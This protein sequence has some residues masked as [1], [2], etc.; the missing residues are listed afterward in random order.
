[1]SASR[2]KKKRFEERADGTDK[3]QVREQNTA[4]NQKRKKLITRIVAIVVVL[5]LLVCIVINSNLFYTG[6]TAV[7]AGDWK[8]TTADFNYEYFNVYYNTYTN[9]Y[10]YYGDYAYLLL[11]PSKSLEDQNYSEEQTWDEY[12]EE[13]AFNQLQQMAILND[14]GKAEGWELD[15]DQLAEIEANIDSIKTEAISQG[16]SDYR[17]YLRALYKKG[18]TEDRL[19]TLLRQS[20]YATYY[21]ADLSARW[22]DS[23]T[24]EAKADYYAGVANTYDLFTYMLYFVDGSVGED[25]ELDADTALNQARDIAQEIASS[26]DQATFADAVYE[27]APEDSKSTYADPNA[28]LQRYVSVSSI[29]NT[30][31]TKWL[32]DSNRISGDTNVFEGTNGFYVMLYV[33]RCANDFEMANFRG[34]AI[35]VE[36]DA[37]TEQ[38]TDATRSAAQA[39]VDMILETFRED[40]TEENFASLADRYDTSGQNLDGGLYQ[41][42]ILGQ[43]AS[44]ELEDF[45]FSGE[46]EPGEVESFYSDGVFYIV[47]LKESGELYRDYIAENLMA[48]EQYASLIEAKKAEYPISTEFAFRFA[49]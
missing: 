43:L 6:M 21:S 37:E 34:I 24:A 36:K 47:Y 20:Y 32:T 30:D 18:I 28:C 46:H 38:I 49:K 1:M 5:A 12:F 8:Y 16:Y 4:K 35:N 10:N 39:T 23:Y 3:R 17:A 11:D 44:T 40:P 14:A 9:I 13:Y 29:S 45:I 48:E 27:Y 25:S 41:N 33:D 15:A 26:G 42:A 22:R 31:W 2:E 19:R 7:R